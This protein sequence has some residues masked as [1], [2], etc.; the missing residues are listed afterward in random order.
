MAPFLVD[1]QPLILSLLFSFGTLSRL[2]RRTPF[3]PLFLIFFSWIECSLWEASRQIERWLAHA[4]FVEVTSLLEP[5]RNCSLTLISQSWNITKLTLAAQIFADLFLTLQY[6][7][8]CQS[9][10]R[11]STLF[12]L[13]SMSLSDRNVGECLHKLQLRPGLHWPINFGD[14]ICDSHSRKHKKTQSCTAVYINNSI[15]FLNL[16]TNTL[17]PVYSTTV[18]NVNN[19]VAWYLGR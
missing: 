6:A 18:N 1:L 3:R 14:S 10:S 16:G 7:S 11:K 9:K 12:H 17:S 13:L 15:N 4:V 5:R 2:K 19:Q 8:H